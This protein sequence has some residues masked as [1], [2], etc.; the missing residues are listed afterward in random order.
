MIVLAV[1]TAGADCSA[2]IIDYAEDAV[3][4]IAVRRDTLGRGHAEHLMPMLRLMLRDSGLGV[5]DMDRFAV[6][7]GPGSFTGLRVGVSAV[8][9]FA[10]ATGRPALGVGTLEALA[11]SHIGASRTGLAATLDARHGNVYIQVFAPDGSAVC[12]PQAMPA[13]DA[14]NL[15]AFDLVVG[16]GAPLIVEAMAGCGAGSSMIL[17][18]MGCPDP[19]VLAQ[20]AAKRRPDEAMPVPLYIKAPDA[21]PARPPI[22]RRTGN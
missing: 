3:R 16:S 4:V 2:A 1:D 8:R 13:K 11:G 12:A 22:P 18:T 21:A 20:L 9:G 7:V 15:P 5:G 17:D 19:V 14:V 10:L 6:T